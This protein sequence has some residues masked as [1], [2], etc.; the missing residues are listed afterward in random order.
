MKTSF[1]LRL[2]IISIAAAIILGAFGAHALENILCPYCT[3]IWE[4]SIF[5]QL[6]NSIGIIL[7]I[8]LQKQQIIKE[9]NTNLFL[10]LMGI[11]LFCGSLY[12]LAIAKSI[13]N[14]QHW[15]KSIMGPLTPI[16]GTFLITGW[17]ITFLNISKK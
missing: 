8:V 9:K 4:K 13:L 11:I 10:L 5:Y 14:E 1:F 6:T 16:G 7:L 12:T 3:E 2:S 15:I 17:I